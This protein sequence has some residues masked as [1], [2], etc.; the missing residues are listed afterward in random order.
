MRR[1]VTAAL[2]AV[3]LAVPTADAAAAIRQAADAAATPKKKVVVK[4]VV[5]P[6]A[7]AHRWGTV[8]VT[9]T[10]KK[11]ITTTGTK[12]TVTRKIT[13]VNAAYEVHTDR[14]VFIMEQALP[15]L[16]ARGAAGAERRHRPR[17]GRH[18]HER[19]V[20]RVAPGG[21]C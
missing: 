11:T 18:R 16:R 13:A 17:L 9:L 12:R 19:G 4:K 21:A 20:R 8:T 10:V 1:A 6:A 15:I 2:T 7:Q 5:G 3:V 14:S